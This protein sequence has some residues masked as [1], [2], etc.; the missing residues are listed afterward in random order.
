METWHNSYKIRKISFQGPPWWSSGSDSELPVQ[1]ARVRPLV[2]EIRAHV[3]HMGYAPQH[4]QKRKKNIF[5]KELDWKCLKAFLLL[6]MQG[7]GRAQVWRQT[8]S[9]VTDSLNSAIYWVKSEVPIL[10]GMGDCFHRFFP[11]T[12]MGEGNAFRMIQEHYT[13]CA[14]Y[15]YYYY[16]QLHLRSSGIRSQR[17]GIHVNWQ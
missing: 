9:P 7:V 11:Q 6:W 14:L 15:I 3:L 4:T 13:Y 16:H 17:L 5:R 8:N 10:F 1:G 2:E 12:R